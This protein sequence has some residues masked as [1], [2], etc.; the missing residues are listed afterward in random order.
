MKK[1]LLAWTINDDPG[2]KRLRDKF[3]GK[4]VQLVI[5]E[6]LPMIDQKVLDSSQIVKTVVSRC[7]QEIAWLVDIKNSGP[8]RY[9]SGKEDKDKGLVLY[10]SLHS[11]LEDRKS[12]V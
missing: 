8:L 10:G 2:I 5:D 6:W 4:G 12:V 3:M 11:S 7:E 1:F 9:I